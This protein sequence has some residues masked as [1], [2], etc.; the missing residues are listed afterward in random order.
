MSM[1]KK[2]AALAA[3]GLGSLGL[4]SSQAEAHDGRNAAIIGGAALG[5]LAGAVIANAAS[6]DQAQPVGWYGYDEPRYDAPPSY[7][8]QPRR[9][10]PAYRPAYSESYV[11][12]RPDRGWHRGWDHGWRGDDWR[13]RRHQEWRRWH[14]DGGWDD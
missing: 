14:D 11:V 5:V 1:L 8:V 6:S 2:A 3:I 13:W 7:Y 12:V 4:L 10:V 9:Y